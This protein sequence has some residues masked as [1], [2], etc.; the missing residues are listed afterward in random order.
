MKA[1]DVGHELLR[2]KQSQTQRARMGV[3]NVDAALHAGAP[4]STGEERLINQGA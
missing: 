1:I 2:K 4:G 3:Q